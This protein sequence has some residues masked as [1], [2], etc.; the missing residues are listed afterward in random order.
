M[1][2]NNERKKALDVAL[3]QIEKQFGKGSVMRLGDYKAMEIESIPTGSLSLDI[4]LGIGGLPRG[5]I[6]EIYGPESS[7]KTTLALSVVAEAQKLGGEAAFLDVD[8]TI[9]ND[10]GIIP[11][12]TQIAIR[13]AVENG[14]K[15]VVC[16]GRSLFQLPQMLLDLGFS[17]MVTAAGAQVIAG[18][19]EIYHA[20]I[21]EEHRKFI[22]DYM[23][24]N[25]FVYCFQTDAGVVMNKRSEQQILKIMS[26]MGITEEHLRQLVG[27]FFIQEDVWNNEKEE[28]L[29]YYD[30]P[31]GVA[32]VHADLEPYFDVVALSLSGA[33][34]YCGEVGIN[35][36]HKATGMK[37]YLE[38]VGIP[39]EDSIAIGDGPNDLQMMDY[40]GIGIAMGNAREEVKKRAD[41]VTSHIDE[42]GLYHALDRLGLLN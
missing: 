26:D 16:S 3:S 34:D 1:A 7:G 37:R 10:K 11:E 24:K 13:K 8:G 32:R 36:I 42:D 40:A 28:K 27:E 12:S 22:V 21:D 39:R 33:D 9:V 38:Y 4:A 30:A 35:G 25:N 18:G 15:L 31:F 5:R 29:I 20:V 23:E 17:G 19:K 6:I 41:M 14:H 2:E